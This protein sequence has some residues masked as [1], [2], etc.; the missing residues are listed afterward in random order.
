MASQRTFH[1]EAEGS[2]VAVV[3]QHARHSLRGSNTSGLVRFGKGLRGHPA[4]IHSHPIRIVPIRIHRVVD[5]LGQVAQVPEVDVTRTGYEC[6]QSTR[7][8]CKQAAS[9]SRNARPQGRRFTKG[10]SCFEEAYYDCD[11]RPA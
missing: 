5:N 1:F 4:R 9:S 10:P 2:A 3:Q 11:A 8:T 7:S 6:P